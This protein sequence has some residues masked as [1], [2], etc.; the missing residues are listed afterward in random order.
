MTYYNVSPP[1]HPQCGCAVKPDIVFFGEGL[2][3]S[4]DN[5]RADLRSCSA[6]IVLGT[7]LKVA[8]FAFLPHTTHKDCMRVLVNREPAGGIAE[9]GTIQAVTSEGVRTVRLAD[10][11]AEERAKHFVVPRANDYFLQGN[12]DDSIHRLVSALGWQE[13]HEAVKAEIKSAYVERR[14]EAMALKKDEGKTIPSDATPCLLPA[15]LCPPTAAAVSLGPSSLPYMLAWVGDRERGVLSSHGYTPS[16]TAGDRVDIPSSVL[17]AVKAAGVDVTPSSLP[18]YTCQ[19][20]ME[21][22]EGASYAYTP[23][24]GHWATY[25]RGYAGCAPFASLDLPDTFDDAW[26]KIQ[27]AQGVDRDADRGDD[28]TVYT[29]DSIVC[30]PTDVS[31]LPFPCS[32]VMTSLRS[33]KALAKIGASVPVDEPSLEVAVLAKPKFRSECQEVCDLALEKAPV[34]IKGL[35]AMGFKVKG[36]TAAVE[37]GQVCVCVTV[38]G[39]LGRER[40]TLLS[41]LP[42]KVK[43][44][45]GDGYVSKCVLKV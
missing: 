35:E 1:P 33:K 43:K 25:C 20:E 5:R 3:D 4:F 31:L 16:S 45:L 18:V 27:L 8:P 42:L 12:A 19:D 21:V 9:P 30:G 7:S 39:N 36:V 44:M 23:L 6:C 15:P 11:P 2:P 38:L 14:L 24:D 41:A 22:A 17:Q 10:L 37:E 26:D 13:E 32:V 40:A 29:T 34:L 28:P